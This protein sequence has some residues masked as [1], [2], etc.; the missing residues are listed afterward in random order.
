M[1]VCVC[2]LCNNM[3]R[4]REYYV[5]NKS[6]RERKMSHDFTYIWTLQHTINKTRNTFKYREQ[7][8][9]C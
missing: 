1:Y 9:S 4:P 2:V 5:S 7:I 6:D 8:G 3:G